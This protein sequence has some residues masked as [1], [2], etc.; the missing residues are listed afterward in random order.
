MT[1]RPQTPSK[2][3]PDRLRAL[4]NI[5]AMET[6]NGFADKAVSGGLDG[7]L[8]TLLREPDAG[9]TIRWLADHGLLSVGYGEL[10]ATLRER[11]AHET[12]RVLATAGTTSEEPA[13]PPPKRPPEKPAAQRRAPR[14]PAPAPAPSP[15]PPP[16]LDAP[17]L[18]LKSVT[19]THVTKLAKMGVETVRDLVFLFP[20]RHLDYSQRRSVA[21]VRPD[22][23]LTIVVS[24]WEARQV[25]MGRGGRL[26]AT[27]AV[28]GDE[29]GNLRVIWFGQ[30]WLAQTLNRAMAKGSQSGKGPP[31]LVLS[32]RV[33]VFN[34][35]Q[36]MESP[37][38]E[39]LD[40]PEAADLVHTGR[41]VPVYPSTEGLPART[42]RRIVREALECVSVDGTLRIEDTLPGSMRER[43][44][45]IGL[46]EAVAQ[47]HYPDSAEAKETARLRLAFDEL[48]VLQLAVAARRGTGK[49]KAAGIPLAPMPEPV[50]AFL[51][52]LPFALTKGQETALAEAMRDVAAAER[53]MS[54]LL[55]GDVGSGKTV[56]ALALL[57][58]AVAAGY[59]GALMAPT[60]VLAEQHF[61]SLRQ[62]LAGLDT[63]PAALLQEPSEGPGWFSV[64]L[65]GHPSPITIAL[66]TGSTRAAARR[67][68][69]QRIADGA[70]DILVGT[71]ALIQQEVELP[72]LA[73]AV[74]DEQ[75]RFGVLQ[76]AALREKGGQGDRRDPHLLLM[77]A[78]PIP[79]TLA[80][81]LYGDLDVS[82]IPE[83]PAGRKE[84]KTRFVKAAQAEGA[85]RFLV[86]QARAGRQ[87]FVVCPLIDES[88]TVLARA[89]TVEYD[90]LRETTL[91]ELTVGLLHGRMALADK[92]AVMDRFRAGEIDVLVATPVIEVGIDVPN[93]T[94]ML[95]EGA[96]RFGLAQLHQLRGRVG[97]GEHQSYCLLLSD[98]LSAD[99]NERLN[100]LVRTNDGFAIAEADLQLRGPGDF[101]GTRQSG[102]P[103]LHMASL[104]DRDL[105]ASARDEARTLLA[106]DPTLA[107]HPQLAEALAHYTTAVSDDVA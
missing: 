85:E 57:L 102:L 92:Q 97:R 28:V 38:W 41:L 68:L 53:P 103:S 79:R 99:A 72:N 3:G 69:R 89:A 4:R 29:T 75:H 46:A 32:G 87:S 82:T 98:A 9:P 73:L 81:T 45:L 83:L 77:S 35:R 47:A 43:L 74:V 7:F 1:S 70:L 94:V 6:A 21:Q 101:F 78:T 27:E 93:A 16:A 96:D 10:D 88:E 61:L 20:N 71:H 63:P 100:V 30:P 66:L 62:M 42:I 107:T 2:S 50:Q 25:Q 86:E 17:V 33:S 67:E 105:L 91:A 54:R 49:Q 90:R 15:P 36:Q 106:A 5:L 11:W 58:T 8:R 19:R 34:G 51:R 59:Q 13:A 31:K 48:L 39:P 26:R 12:A 56:V 22:E 60:E 52:S 18:Q 55:Q 37:E 80:L 65:A 64:R 23:D 44:G 76:R 84:I 14:K 104:D 40:D 95:I 24:L